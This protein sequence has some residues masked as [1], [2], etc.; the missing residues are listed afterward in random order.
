MISWAKR[1]FSRLAMWSAKKSNYKFIM[2]DWVP[3]RDL[4]ALSEALESKRFSQNL[5]CVA[6]D[7]P[8]ARKALVIAPHPDDDTLSSGGTLLRLVRKGCDV[9]VLYL[10]SGTDDRIKKEAEEVS[11]ELGTRVEFWR[12]PAKGIEITRESKERL[13]R[14][15]SDIRPDIIFIPFIAD[16]H[17]DHR[18]AAQ[19]FYETFKDVRDLDCEVWAYQGYSTVLSNVAVDITDVIDRKTEL[20][21]LW[22][23]ARAHRDW[24][25]YIR[26]LNAFNSRFLKTKEPRYAELFFVVP[27]S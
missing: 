13:K 27:A 25:H 1:L 23:T 16:D 2:K 18:R 14:L 12:Y 7:T 24:A 3:L 20:V 26:G 8:K 17:D 6:I 21:N 5:E 9:T 19:L 10:T 11:S 15:C 4:N 22:K